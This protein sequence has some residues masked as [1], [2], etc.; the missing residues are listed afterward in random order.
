VRTEI[1]KK[2]KPKRNRDKKQ[3]HFASLQEQ[4]WCYTLNSAVP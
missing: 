2:E 1:Q 4:E 3:D